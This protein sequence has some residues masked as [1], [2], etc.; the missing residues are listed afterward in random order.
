MSDIRQIFDDSL[1][2][3][4]RVTVRYCRTCG[5]GTDRARHVSVITLTLFL[6]VLTKTIVLEW[7]I[8]IIAHAMEKLKQASK[9]VVLV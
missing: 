3:T 2:S 7:K 1:L 9:H 8:H 6:N 4:Q 5:G